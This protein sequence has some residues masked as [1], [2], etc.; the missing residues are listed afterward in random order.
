[1]PNNVI[2]VGIGHPLRGDDSLGF[3]MIEALIGQLP[4]HITLAKMLGDM[5][6]LLDMFAQYSQVFLVDAIVTG[7]AMPGTIHRLTEKTLSL[8]SYCRASTHSFDLGQVI[9]LARSL[10]ALPQALIIYGIEAKQF[11]HGK[12]LSPE[13]L[14]Q[15]DVLKEKI[16]TEV[17]LASQV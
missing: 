6:E 16:I 5:I 11:E 9:E 1:M 17:L 10:Q 3:N 14:A 7:Q 13:V 8:S 15:F 2:V 4:N 12:S